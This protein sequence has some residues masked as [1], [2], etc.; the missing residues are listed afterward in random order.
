MYLN[1][2]YNI[3]INYLQIYN[4]PFIL[5]FPPAFILVFLA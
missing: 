4:N 5:C 1:Y 2:N 3:W